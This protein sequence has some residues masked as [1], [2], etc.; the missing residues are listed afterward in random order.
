MNRNISRQFSI[1]FCSLLLR[2]PY[3]TG[4]ILLSALLTISACKS[5][6]GAR[7]SLDA[8]SGSG[9]IESGGADTTGIFYGIF[10]LCKYGKACVE[11]S[12]DIASAYICDSPS[13]LC[14]GRL[15]LKE[16]DAGSSCPEGCEKFN[17][18][19]CEYCALTQFNLKKE[20]YWSPADDEPN[21]SFCTMIGEEKR[22]KMISCFEE[23]GLFNAIK[24]KAAELRGGSDPDA[25]CAT[26]NTNA[27]D[28][29]AK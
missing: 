12:Y 4:F 15:T 26:E 19:S 24:A 16:P 2:S 9:N 17:G 11:E 1:A 29:G 10:S 6:E 13:C 22:E 8:S 3:I 14:Q 7:N 5:D 21:R 25:A 23:S 20:D 28:S 27:D 18:N